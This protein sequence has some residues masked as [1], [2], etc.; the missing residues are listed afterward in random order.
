VAVD[1]G[2]G[3]AI[4]VVREAHARSVTDLARQRQAIAERI[5]AGRATPQDLGGATF[6][7]SN[8]GMRRVDE[9]TAIITPPQAAILA[10]GTIVDRV[11]AVN[12]AP[13]VRP[14]MHLMLSSDHRVVDGAR[15]AAFMDEL[16]SAIGDPETWLM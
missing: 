4:A 8:L 2:N 14:T 5:R 10:V 15:A 3:V 6:T 7:L 9:F 16:A 13:A 11:V 1:A 12:G